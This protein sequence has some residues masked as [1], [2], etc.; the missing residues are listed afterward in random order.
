[1]LWETA[2]MELPY[3]FPKKAIWRG[4]G[5]TVLG[6][7]INSSI[8]SLPWAPSQG[9]RGHCGLSGALLASSSIAQCLQPSSRHFSVMAWVVGRAEPGHSGVGMGGI[10]QAAL[11]LHHLLLRCPLLKMPFTFCKVPTTTIEFKDPM[12]Y[13][14]PLTFPA[15]FFF[16]LIGHLIFSELRLGFQK[17]PVF[18]PKIILASLRGVISRYQLQLKRYIYY[19]LS[20]SPKS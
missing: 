2:C 20:F 11:F 5:D 3:V 9:S 6:K 15:F 7:R 18:C 12:L 16:F 4:C 14:L 13:S 10:H 17:L 1:M 8:A 19:L